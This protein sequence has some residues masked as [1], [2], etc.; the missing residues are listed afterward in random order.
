MPK[1]ADIR[2][3]VCICTYRRQ[4]LLRELLRGIAKLT[5]RK[6]SAPQLTIIV[7]DNTSGESGSAQEICETA[8]LP[9]PIKYVVEPRHG[10]TYARNR[11]I[12]EVGSVD[13]V[14]FI[15][16]DEVPSAHWLDELLWTQA[17]FAADVVSGPVLPRYAPD[18]A[19]WV[20][21]GGF[22]EARVSPTGTT[23][24]AC[25]TNNVLVGT[26]IFE[27]VPKFDDAFALSGAEDSDFFLRVSAAGHKI[28]WSQE[29]VVFEAISAERA[30]ARWILRREYQT[31]NGWIFCE[32]GVDHRLRSRMFRFSK[33][34]GHVA[35]GSVNAIWRS[36]LL[37]RTGVVR[38]LQRV[39]LGGGM[40]AALA[41]FRFLAYRG[42]GTKESRA[43]T[44]VAGRRERTLEP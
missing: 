19:D 28:V 43:L 14:A 42:A 41:G 27:R 30:T 23:R 39:C 16:D 13:F 40:L 1:S 9:W 4:K 12:A 11:A 6:V 35:L 15:D 31:G 34:W 21:R 26:H 44:S 18:V 20:R 2:V 8:S 22:F 38:S 25:A 24:K 17:E 5:F 29:A 10:L 3:A 37:D 7:V 33:P 36:V 32:A